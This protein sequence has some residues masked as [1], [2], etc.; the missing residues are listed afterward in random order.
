MMQKSQISQ[1]NT[2]HSRK[3]T[4]FRKVSLLAVIA[5]LQCPVDVAVAQ[6]HRVT[7]RNPTHEETTLSLPTDGPATAPNVMKTVALAVS[8]TALADR[9]SLA[10]NA[11]LPNRPE[12]A[13]IE[14]QLRG[15][16]RARQIDLANRWMNHRLEFASDQEVYGE[17]DHWA[18]L[19]ES[20]PRGRGDCEDYAI[21]K[22]QL[23]RAAGVPTK[24]M[25]MVIARDLVRRQDHALLVVRLD[26]DFM[27]LDSSNDLLLTDLEVRD[28]QPV[29]SFSGEQSWLHGYQQKPATI[30][31]SRDAAA[32]GVVAR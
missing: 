24:D 10:A 11:P 15:Q 1:V 20:L 32:P 25:Y 5:A 18:P 13:D 9:W 7:V 4:T 17:A 21:G 14:R 8:R 3:M 31:A 27:V 23:L 12:V 26:D 16:P 22:M 19:S 2:L 29:M 28:Y 6:P 30:I